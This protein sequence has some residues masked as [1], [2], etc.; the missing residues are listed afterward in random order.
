MKY[1]RKPNEVEAI[2]WDGKNLKDLLELSPEIER[3]SDTLLRV[4][5]THLGLGD[6]LILDGEET[7]VCQ[8][9]NFAKSFTKGKAPKAKEPIPERILTAIKLPPADD[10]SYEAFLTGYIKRLICHTGGNMVEAAKI[11]GLARMTLYRY[12]EKG[13]LLAVRHEQNRV[14]TAERRAAYNER[15]RKKT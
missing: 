10:Y 6:W 1:L 3:I 15:R 11:S 7:S 8:L 4:N 14:R 9:P 12:I 13:D 2:Q 5:G